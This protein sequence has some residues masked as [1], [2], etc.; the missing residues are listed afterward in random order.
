[1]TFVTKVTALAVMA[2]WMMACSVDAEGPELL[3]S[4]D[5]ALLNKGTGGTSTKDNLEA[6][7]YTCSALEETSL[8]LCWKNGSPSYS[9]D[10]Q[11]RCIQN[12]TR[13]PIT[14]PIVGPTPTVVAPIAP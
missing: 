7:G 9:C 6:N 14:G 11:G 10:P 1:M 5:Q 2:S 12:L 4:T 3:G 13:P 8:T